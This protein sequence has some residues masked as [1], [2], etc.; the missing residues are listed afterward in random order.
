M[1]SDTQSTQLTPLGRWLKRLRAQNDLTQEALAERVNCSVQTIR[2]FESGRRRPSWET[3][4]LL[5]DALHVPADEREEFIRT[6]RQVPTAPTADAAEPEPIAAPPVPVQ[7]L[8][9]PRPLTPLIGRAAECGLL[10]TLLIEERRPLVTLV[11]T[12]GMGKTR[13]ALHVAHWLAPRFPD[14]AAFVAL[15]S[16]QQAGELPSAIARALG[17]PLAGDSDAVAQLDAL[18]AEQTLLLV[19]DS[20]EHLLAGGDEAVELVSHIV[21]QGS[22]VQLLVTSTER[23]RSGGRID[24][25]IGRTGRGGRDRRAGA[26]RCGIALCRARAAGLPGFCPDAGQPRQRSNGSA[27]CSKA[28]RWAW[29]W[30]RRGRAC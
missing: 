16:V 4:E 11:G 6:A 24:R 15:S 13:L 25:R 23:L 14:G 9:L 22:G 10:E 12:G 30:R 5:A 17:S 18:L 2:F 28:C 7:S 19:L 27:R 20:F 21:A 1:A 3:A 29:N 8:R 26:G